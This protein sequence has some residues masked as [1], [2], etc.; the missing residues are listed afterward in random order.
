MP[1][2][3]DRDLTGDVRCAWHGIGM[4]EGDL[5]WSCPMC[6]RP[7]GH[8]PVSGQRRPSEPDGTA[9]ASTAPEPLD[10]ASADTGDG[11]DLAGLR[12]VTR[13]EWQ[14]R[15]TVTGTTSFAIEAYGADAKLQAI[16]WLGVDGDGHEL[17]LAEYVQWVTPWRLVRSETMSI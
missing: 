4:V 9:G 5:G 13:R 15:N 14:V 2:T 7:W 11:P 1:S 12:P 3:T 10:S 6:P 17:V 8:E 16:H